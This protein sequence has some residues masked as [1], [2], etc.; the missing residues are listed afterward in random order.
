MRRLNIANGD[1]DSKYFGGFRETWR[2][3][4]AMGGKLFN[5][6]MLQNNR[7]NMQIPMAPSATPHGD[8]AFSD[9]CLRQ[10]RQTDS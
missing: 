8:S 3:G 6:H 2:W 10:L 9:R 4:G 5:H 7:R 1:F